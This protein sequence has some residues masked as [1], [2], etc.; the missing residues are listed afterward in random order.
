MLRKFDNFVFE[1]ES[2]NS[3]CMDI[4]VR[5]LFENYKGN[6]E[7]VCHELNRKLKDKD[8]KVSEMLFFPKYNMF[9]W[10]PLMNKYY[11]FEYAGLCEVGKGKEKEYYIIYDKDCYIK[12]HR[13]L[14]IESQLHLVHFDEKPK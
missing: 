1:S 13:N 4:D 3:K 2:S 6:V 12:L 10:Q 14:T 11:R 7:L 8:I 9:K 5:A